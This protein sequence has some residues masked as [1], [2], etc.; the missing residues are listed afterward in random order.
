[1]KTIFAALLVLAPFFARTDAQSPAKLKADAE[2]Y[3]QAGKYAQALDMYQQLQNLKPGNPETIKNIGIASYHTNNLA[4]AKQFLSMAAEQSD[5]TALL[6]LAK[7]AHQQLDF[8]EAIRYY[9]LFLNAAK[10][11]YPNRRAAIADIKRCATGLKISKQSELALVEN[12]GDKINTPYD[13]FAPVQSPNY[14][15]RLYF[16]SARDD[17]EGGLRNEAGIQ[18]SLRG[19]PSSDIYFTDAENGEWTPPTPINNGLVNTSRNES[20]LGFDESGKSMYFFRG[21]TLF[22]G[23]ILKDIYKPNEEV[24]A[25]PKNL[26]SPMQPELGDNALFF[27]RDTILIFASRR[28]GGYGGLDLYITTFS[29][30]SW[31][32]PKNLGPSINSAYDETTPF[33]SKD[34]RTLYFSS[35][36]TRSMGGF[37]VFKSVFNDNDLKWSEPINLGVP[38]NSAG[39]DVSFRLTPDGMKAYFCSDRKDNSQGGKDIFVALFKNYQREQGKPSVPL[40]F[41]Q[42]ADYKAVLQATTASIP[43]DDKKPTFEEGDYSA[44]ELQ[45]AYYN[46]DDDLLKLNNTTQ[47]DRLAGMMKKFPQLKLIITGNCAQGERGQF[48]LYFTLKRLEKLTT[49]LVSKGAARENILLKSVGSNYPIARTELNGQPNPAGELM[50]KRIDFHF[51]NIADFPI[52][53]ATPTAI[54]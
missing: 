8:K 29:G 3:F 21:F 42:V 11:E 19:R 46:E 13:E 24:R 27:F 17:S 7:T 38:I 16:S 33:L 41:D 22:S 47:L 28:P 51:P 54:V 25:L 52:L 49:Y 36:S 43:S 14:D 50:N 2:A 37:D 5:P 44:L 9:K 1:M 39:D 12:I 6:Y 45:P 26:E 20:I 30:G 10:T 53:Q 15:D 18:D 34:G 31:T 32:M 48:D 40:C 35:N 23:E 4:Q